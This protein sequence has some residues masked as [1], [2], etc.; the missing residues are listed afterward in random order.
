[1]RVLTE[2]PEAEQHEEGGVVTR[3]LVL[4][5][6]NTHH[7]HLWYHYFH[8]ENAIKVLK[9]CLRQS[10]HKMNG[11]AG[12]QKLAKFLYLGKKLDR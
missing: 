6:Y 11:Y 5:F 7:K 1:M 2:Q 9:C 4:R 10:G 12:Y 3:P 8:A